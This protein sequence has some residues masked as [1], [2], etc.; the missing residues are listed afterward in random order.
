MPIYFKFDGEEKP[1]DFVLSTPILVITH[2]PDFSMPFNV[3]AV[4]HIAF[5]SL[6][7]NTF[8]SLFFSHKEDQDDKDDEKQKKKEEALKES[9]TKTASL[10]DK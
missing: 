6:F 1:T 10:D 8:A 9:V 5:G 2:T 3:N 4:T 7:I